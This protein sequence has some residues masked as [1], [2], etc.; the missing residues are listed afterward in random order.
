VVVPVVAIVTAVVYGLVSW[1][2][3]DLFPFS[4]YA[5]YADLGGRAEGAVLVVRAGGREV[6][7]HEVVAWFGVDPEL[8]EPFTVPCSLHWVVFEAQRWI[9]GH[10]RP[11]REGLDVP[12]EVG[13][14]IL[15]VTPGVVE[16]RFEA[17]GA[18]WGRLR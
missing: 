4:R 16:E 10:T 3:G 5:M 7:F 14:R 6:E 13:Y 2:V 18:G 8:I 9:A 12:I 1:R 15:K 11:T 17:R